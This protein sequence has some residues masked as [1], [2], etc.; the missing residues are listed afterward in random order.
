MFFNNEQ[1]NNSCLLIW[2]VVLI[3]DFYYYTIQMA[4]HLCIL[5]CTLSKIHILIYISWIQINSD[6]QYNGI[7]QGCNIA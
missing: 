7:F 2:N 6:L 3:Y 5:K 4:K 1:R